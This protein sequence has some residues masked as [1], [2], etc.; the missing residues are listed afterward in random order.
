MSKEL[1]LKS[2][3]IKYAI[4]IELGNLISNL[5]FKRLNKFLVK[6]HTRIFSLIIS[7]I[8]HYQ[9]HTLRETARQS[10]MHIYFNHYKNFSWYSKQ[11]TVSGMNHLNT[12]KTSV[13][14]SVI[15]LSS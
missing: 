1:S 12:Y 5:F 9:T 6:I 13:S 2:I 7:L 11:L 4:H 10:T 15:I 14:I 8:M 3:C